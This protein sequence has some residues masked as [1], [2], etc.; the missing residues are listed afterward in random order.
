MVSLSPYLLHDGTNLLAAEVH[1]ATASA[2]DMTFDLGLMANA[3]TPH[4]TQVFPSG[5]TMFTP[6]L[7]PNGSN[8]V[9]ISQLI[10]NPPPGTTVIIQTPTGMV[11]EQFDDIDMTW[12]PGT[13]R[14]MAGYGAKLIN[15]MGMFQIEISGLPPYP[16]RTITTQRE[17]L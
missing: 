9:L 6:Q 1:Q 7:I 12:Y 13:T 2:N 3:E 5:A 17:F 15:P 8:S 11:S 14:L 4:Y 10:P 16:P